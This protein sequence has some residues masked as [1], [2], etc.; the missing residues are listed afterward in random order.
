MNK[1]VEIKSIATVLLNRVFNAEGLV[2]PN[3]NGVGRTRLI[4]DICLVLHSDHKKDLKSKKLKAHYHNNY[5]CLIDEF[6]T[7]R[8]DNGYLINSLMINGRKRDIENMNFFIISPAGRSIADINL[9]QHKTISNFRYYNSIEEVRDE[10]FN[11]Y[12]MIRKSI[13]EKENIMNS[14]SIEKSS[15]NNITKRRL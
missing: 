5:I 1:N 3:I 11:N 9:I 14:I 13:I 15:N 10:F 4:N 2:L 8:N 12:S 7:D 6:G